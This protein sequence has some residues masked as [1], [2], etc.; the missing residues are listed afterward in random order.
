VDGVWRLPYDTQRFP[1]A[2]ECESML[3]FGPLSKLHEVH[4]YELRKR[5]NDQETLFHERFYETFP[6][7]WFSGVYEGFMRERI[8]PIFGE[9]IVIQ[10]IPSFRV[11]LPGN[12]AVG[13]FHK[14]GDYGH[15]LDEVN[16]WVPLTEATV[17]NTIIIRLDGHDRPW[18]CLVG[19]FLL[20]N[21]AAREHGNLPSDYDHT[22][23][24]FDARVI[25]ASKY[26]PREEASINA[27]KRFA[28]GDYFREL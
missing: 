6:G 26:Q 13:E 9:P 16:V 8:Q 14:D 24:S 15:G 25:P 1:L 22:R 12:L 28:V 21:G 19:D 20:F 27:G 7:S 4:D 5:E 23:V 10:T 18:P 17:V 2:Q 3:G 11:Q